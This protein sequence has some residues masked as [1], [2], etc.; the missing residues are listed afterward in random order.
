MQSAK[1]VLFSNMRNSLPM[2]PRMGNS[3]LWIWNLL[4][5][6]PATDTLTTCRVRHVSSNL[7]SGEQRP[8]AMCWLLVFWF[9]LE[10]PCKPMRCICWHEA[11]GRHQTAHVQSVD[12]CSCVCTNGKDNFCTDVC[13]CRCILRALVVLH[14]AGFAH[15]DVHWANI[16]LQHDGTWVLIDLES[17]CVLDTVPYTP[18]RKPAHM[19]HL[20]CVLCV[21]LLLQTG[22]CKLGGL[23]PSIC[24]HL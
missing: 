18:D 4:G 3:M 12:R 14:Q 16:I 20:L 8:L 9:A 11:L 5:S 19:L 7:A 2:L 17:A 15:T 1:V 10:L 13:S 6:R 22:A 23:L 24:H 21:C